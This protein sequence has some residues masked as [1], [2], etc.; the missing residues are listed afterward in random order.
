VSIT[1]QL[2]RLPPP[3]GRLYLVEN[4]VFNGDHI[5]LDGYHFRNC[6]FAECVF[7]ISAGNF[8]LEECFLQTNW[9]VKFEGNAQKVFK[10]ASMMDWQSVS[11]NYKPVWHPSGGVSIT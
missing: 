4:L 6:A 1:S 7:H 9:W 11:P 2:P 10:L 5:Q 8:K 3:P